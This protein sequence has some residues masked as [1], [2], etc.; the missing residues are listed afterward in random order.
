MPYTIQYRPV[1]FTKSPT[2][3]DIV[4]HFILL[5]LVLKLC[6]CTINVNVDVYC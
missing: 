3:G 2:F 5:F 1:T 6:T 4:E